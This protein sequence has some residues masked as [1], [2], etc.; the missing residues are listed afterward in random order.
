MEK[1]PQIPV[2]SQ[3]II[4]DHQIPDSPWSYYTETND[5]QPKDLRATP[6]LWFKILALIHDL[7]NFAK[8]GAARV[9]LESV[10]DPFYMSF[11]YFDKSEATTIKGITVD[12]YLLQKNDNLD[13]GEILSCKDTLEHVLQACFERLLRKREASGTRDFRPCTAH[14]LAP[15]LCTLL[16]VEKE[17]LKDE[18][19]QSRLARS[20]GN[21]ESVTDTPAT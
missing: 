15:L 18:K 9:R 20:R 3:E 2:S 1:R 17:E 16:G 19:F 21:L 10:T 5:M 6:N 12:D 13:L 8:D 11:P 7:Q 14:D 4:F